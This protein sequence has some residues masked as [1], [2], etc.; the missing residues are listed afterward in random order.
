MTRPRLANGDVSRA[1]RGGDAFS[2]MAAYL[3]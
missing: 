1:H 2:G 3:V